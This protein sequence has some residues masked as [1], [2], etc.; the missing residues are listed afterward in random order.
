MFILSAACRDVAKSTEI[1]EPTRNR[2]CKNRK[3]QV[4]RKPS[5]I[6]HERAGRI[7]AGLVVLTTLTLGYFHHPLWFLPAVGICSNL[8][9]SGITDRC[10]VRD[11]LL[12]KL[13]GLPGERDIGR[14]EAEVLYRPEVRP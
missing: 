14:K 2:L 1:L 10:A 11:H 9:F 6:S 4:E 5:P 3:A 13:L 8:I 12:I 7:L